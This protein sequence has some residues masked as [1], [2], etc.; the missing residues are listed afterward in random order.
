MLGRRWI[1]IFV[2]WFILNLPGVPVAAAAQ[3]ATEEQWLQRIRSDVN[4]VRKAK[5]EIKLSQL[6]LAQ[7]QDAYAHGQV[8]EGAKLLGA[9]VDEMQTAWKFL[10]ESGRSAARQPEGFR[11]LDIALREHERALRD[12]ARAVSYFDRAPIESAAR[13]FDQMRD[14][15]IHALF[16]GQKKSPSKG[17]PAPPAAPGAGS[18]PAAR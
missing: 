3:R 2:G 18:P 16:P 14:E 4:P 10:R 1:P 9:L 12:L 17:S 5:D 11:E 7:V 13:Q 8:E 6:K 15:V